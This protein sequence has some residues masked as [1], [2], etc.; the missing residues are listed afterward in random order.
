MIS[1]LVLKKEKKNKND[2]RKKIY[3]YEERYQKR[4]KN[5]L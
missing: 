4:G 5:S 1:L 2:L 3:F